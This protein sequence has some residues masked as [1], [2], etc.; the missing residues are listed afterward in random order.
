MNVSVITVPNNALKERLIEYGIRA[1]KIQVIPVGFEGKMFTSSINFSI[2]RKK[3]GLP[4]EAFIITYL[5]SPLT[6]RGTDTLIKAAKILKARL[7]NFKIIILSRTDSFLEKKEE[8]FLLSLIKKFD[9]SNRICV[10]SGVLNQ[11]IV[12]EYIWASDIIALPF[13]IVP[14]E[15]PL[16][17]LESMACSKPV[18]TT[19]TCGLAEL[20]TPDRGLLVKPGDP[21]DLALAIYEVA[22]DPNSRNE[23]G[24]KAKE[25]ISKLPD[26]DSVGK[27]YEHLFM[28]LISNKKR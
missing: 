25:F 4:A 20:I 21:E 15:P 10:I 7:E 28:T 9:L 23:L 2:V 5:G 27:L 24:R 16:S 8:M 22:Q 13:K 11:K 1:E 14:S 17:L 6:I 19:S 26:W 12:R 3:L 18:I